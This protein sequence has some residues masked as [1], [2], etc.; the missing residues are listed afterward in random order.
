M[1]RICI[2]LKDI[3]APCF[4]I[5]KTGSFAGFACQSFDALLQLNFDHGAGGGKQISKNYRRNI[6]QGMHT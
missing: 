2:E 1:D 3:K 6:K 5:S 4:S